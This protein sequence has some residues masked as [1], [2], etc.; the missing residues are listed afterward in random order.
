[1]SCLN[2]IKKFMVHGP[3]EA[4]NPNAPCMVNGRCS[5][6]FP[7]PFRAET[8]ITEDSYACTRRSDT[9]LTYEVR[10][11]Q[12]NNQWVVCYSKYLIWKYR[13]HINIESIASIK[14]IKYI[15]KYVYKGHDRTTMEF[16]T[17]TDEVKLYLDVCYISS[18]EAHWRLY[19]FNMQEHV[20]N[21]VRLQVHLPDEQ[22]VVWNAE[23]EGNLQDI[24]AQVNHDTTLTGWFRANAELED[25]DIHDTLYQDFPSKMVWNQR[26][27]KWT[28]RQRGFAIGRMY[29]AHPTS[30]EHFYL[31]LLLTSVRGAT[32]FADLYTFEG[33]QYPSFRE[34]YIACGLLEDDQEWD[35]CLQEA[36]QMQ[37]GH[38]LRHLFVTILCDCCPADPKTLWNNFWHHICDD[39]RY[40]LQHKGILA[41]PSPADIQ[42]YGLYLI[43]QLLSHS[44]KR[45][46]DWPAMPQ[47]V[48]NWGAMLGNHLIAEQHQY[49]L[50]EQAV[51]A[52][53]CID[54]LNND[55][56]NAF[57]KITSA[58]S[59]KSG[60]IFSFHDGPRGTGKT[61]LYN[62]C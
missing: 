41:H 50:E 44:G 16:G 27:H 3:C 21:V 52:A 59:T 13:C 19:L 37:T 55:Q 26:Q 11:K 25:D 33:T 60:E 31:C 29:H 61:Y 43:D 24:A 17:C 36:S 57:V 4:Q 2:F 62:T 23:Q 58:V 40:Q 18:C 10:G 9:H 15:Y 48:G 22:A 49:D 20:P 32:S 12:V 39:L 7:K 1:M 53:E 54:K 51:R 56:H 5:K 42:D 28:V 34:A 35:Q 14:A 45:L 8:T 46:E 47:V 30:G 38:Q 6:G